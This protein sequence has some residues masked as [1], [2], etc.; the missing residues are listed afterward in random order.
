MWGERRARSRE[1]ALPADEL[2]QAIDGI[3]L[4]VHAQQQARLRPQVLRCERGAA[5]LLV[6]GEL[7][8]CFAN[9][10]VTLAPVREV[11][12]APDVV[13]VVDGRPARSAEWH[14]RGR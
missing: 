8:A 14:P 3:F 9:L 10:V 6:F 12:L 1:S 2:L 11:L 13:A 5:L 4:A 7:P